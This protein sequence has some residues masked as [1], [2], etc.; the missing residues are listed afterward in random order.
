M[1]TARFKVNSH[2]VVETY[3]VDFGG[4]TNRRIAAPKQDVDF[5]INRFEEHDG[6]YNI[7]VSDTTIGVC[8]GGQVETILNVPKSMITI[9]NLTEDKNE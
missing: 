1:L 2:F 5:N 9:A 4:Y 7:I 8:D 6:Y 3:G